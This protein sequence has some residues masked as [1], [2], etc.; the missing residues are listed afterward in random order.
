M[1][2]GI[3]GSLNSPERVTK[4]E[5]QLKLS[6]TRDFCWGAPVIKRSVLKQFD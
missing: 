4:T 1:N 6:F 5:C 2:S 3:G